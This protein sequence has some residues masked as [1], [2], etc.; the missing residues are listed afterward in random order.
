MQL[1]GVSQLLQSARKS[2]KKRVF[3]L[4]ESHQWSRHTFPVRV[5]IT[6]IERSGTTLLSTLLKQ[7]PLLDG[8]FECG[9]LLAD[10]PQNYK[11][12]HPWYEWMQQPVTVHQWGVSAEHMESI[13]SSRSWGE[14]YRK[15]L[16][17][18]PVFEGDRSQQVCDKTPRYLSCL[19]EVLDKLPNFVPCIVVEKDIESLWRSHKK[20]NMQL[21]DFCL[22]FEQYNNGL[23]RALERHADRVYRVQYEVLCND[24]YD[25]LRHI[26]S[27]IDMEFKREYALNRNSEIQQYYNKHYSQALPLSKEE[28]LRLNQVKNQFADLLIT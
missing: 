6:G 1:N 20:R 28:L 14:A 26:F 10:S 18:S 4:L 16:K 24:L 25:Q 9:F 27:I 7:A 23:R 22:H 15:L 13:C 21:E 8:G 17:Y 3:D 5:V 19:D 11:N 2:F 12:V